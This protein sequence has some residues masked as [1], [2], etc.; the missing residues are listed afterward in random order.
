MP[1]TQAKEIKVHYHKSTAF[2]MTAT[3]SLILCFSDFANVRFF[4]DLENKTIDFRFSVR[5]T[6]LPEA[7]VRILA[8]DEKSLREVGQWPWPRATHAQLVRQLKALGAKCVLYDVFFSE[9]ERTQEK[10]LGQLQTV[11]NASIQGS[12]KSVGK[13]R[14]NVLADIKKFQQTQNGDK[15]FADALKETNNVFLPIVPLNDEKDGRIPNFDALHTTEATLFGGFSDVFPTAQSLVV[16]IPDLQNNVEDS[17]HIRFFQDPD[18]IFRYYPTVMAYQGK[19]IPHLS[20]QVARYLLDDKKPIKVYIADH[21]EVAGRKIPI[22]DNGLA[23]INYCGP[24]GTFQTVSATDVLNNRVASDVFKDAAVLIGATADGLFDLRPTPFNK[25]NPGVEIHANIIEN[26]VAD[27]FMTLA[28]NYWFLLL[29]VVLGM[30]IWYL[31]PRL[32]PF[33]GTVCFVL[34]FAGYIVVAC[35]AFIFGNV[36][37]NVTYP[38]LSMTLTFL[39]LTTYKFRTEVRHSRYMKQMFQSMVTPKVVDEILKL[40]AGIELGGEEKELTVMFSDIRGFT[41]YSEKHTPPE[42]VA[43]LNEYLTQMTNLIFQTEGTLDKYIGD[44]IMAFWGAPTTQKDHA[45]RACSTALGMVDLLH[46]MLHPKWDLEGKE[47]LEIGI[48]I[49]SGNMVVGFVGSQSI[50]NYTLIGDAVNLGSRLEGTTKEYHVEIIISETV[51]D[52]VQNDMLCRELDLIRVKG[53]TQPIRIYELVD[54]R[55]RAVGA[56]EMKVNAFREGLIYYR[57]QRWDDAI[58]SFK[59]CLELD[60]NDGPAKIFTERCIQLKKDPPPPNWDGVFTMKTK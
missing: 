45:Y 54:H 40:P 32:S 48:G 60:P 3:I 20:V 39:V 9:P 42:V 15:E 36:I 22:L 55:L 29:I 41:T 11:L 12:T 21:V 26:I 16:S 4:Q 10:M 23:F 49:N 38:I 24:R 1:E 53:K 33:W 28:P 52:H 14:E 8:V 34:L 31:V 18:G 35:L 47:K 57:T 56:K 19:L 50:K 2:W 27:K 51:F 37:I 5:G 43:I 58:K 46:A 30:L 17:G 44:A 6:R 13:I 25:A 59:N 7:P